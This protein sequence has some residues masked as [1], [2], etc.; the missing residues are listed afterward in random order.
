[1]TQADTSPRA[2]DHTHEQTGGA[3]GAYAHE[4]DGGDAHWHDEFGEHHGE[5]MSPEEAQAL[6]EHLWKLENVELSTV[7]VDVG[8][9]TSHLMFSRVHMQRIGQGLSSRF[10]VVNREVLWRSPILLTPYL[11]DNTIDSDQLG[12]FIHESYREAGIDRSGID[13]GAI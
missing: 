7:G 13:S 1:M 10:V 11:D 12:D 4:H 5:G 9:S 6:S 3:N 2:A 8:S